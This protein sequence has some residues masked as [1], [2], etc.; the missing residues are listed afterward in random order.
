MPSVPEAN[1]LRK[2]FQ[3]ACESRASALRES[4]TVK[5]SYPPQTTDQHLQQASAT[6]EL[7]SALEKQVGGAHYKDLGAYQPWLVL[8]ASMTEDEFRGYMKGTALVYLLRAGMSFGDGSTSKESR[9][10]KVEIG[11]FADGALSLSVTG[12]DSDGSMDFD[13]VF[14]SGAMRGDPMLETQ[15]AVLEYIAAKV[16]ASSLPAVRCPPATD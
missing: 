12:G 13:L 11:Q 9:M 5:S 3:E 4:V 10:Y 15:R 2:D 16:N 1:K 7:R 14:A 6:A 8:K